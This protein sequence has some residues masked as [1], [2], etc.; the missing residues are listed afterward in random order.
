[1]HDH[2]NLDLTAGNLVSDLDWKAAL[3]VLILSS[4][5]SHCSTCPCSGGWFLTTICLS[6][7]WRSV[8]AILWVNYC[9][10]HV[11]VFLCF[12]HKHEGQRSTAIITHILCESVMGLKFDSEL[13]LTGQEEHSF[14]AG[15][16]LSVCPHGGFHSQVCGSLCCSWVTARRLQDQRGPTGKT[17][18][19]SYD[20]K[21][22]T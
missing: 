19:W 4:C 3:V 13:L 16:A 2:Y 1:M 12:I 20:R 9:H 21:I 5:C 14:H 7:Y 17:L 6:E 22:L 15:A 11:Q 10:Q 18:F 8:R